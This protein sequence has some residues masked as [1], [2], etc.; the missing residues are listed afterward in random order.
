MM[1]KIRQKPK[2]YIEKAR[3]TLEE[4]SIILAFSR[5]LEYGI[6]FAYYTQ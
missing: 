2:M 1:P 6:Y 4:C 3:I 5:F